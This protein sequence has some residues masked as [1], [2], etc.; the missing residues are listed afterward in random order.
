MSGLTE[1]CFCI[2]WLQSDR[3]PFILAYDLKWMGLGARLKL[4]IIYMTS[5]SI[6]FF[7]SWGNNRRGYLSLS[8]FFLTSRQGV[9]VWFFVV[10]RQAWKAAFWNANSRLLPSGN[11]ES[12]KRT[13]S[14]EFPQKRPFCQDCSP[15]ID[16]LPQLSLNVQGGGT[17]CPG[18]SRVAKGSQSRMLDRLVKS[19]GPWPA[20]GGPQEN[21]P[22]MSKS[23]ML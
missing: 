6:G 21:A 7:D 9:C 8:G 23:S 5:C 11:H 14:L 18:K 19:S 4:N 12:S 17:L 13:G 3:W 20:A 10:C 2:A 15:Q 1:L 22:G 16:P